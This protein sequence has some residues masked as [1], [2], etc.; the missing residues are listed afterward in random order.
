MLDNCGEG[1][2]LQQTYAVVLQEGQ[3]TAFGER[4]QIYLD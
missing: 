4:T 1:Q 3:Q 2:I